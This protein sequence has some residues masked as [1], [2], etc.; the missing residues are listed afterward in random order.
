MEAGA[1]A[2]FVGCLLGTA[3]SALLLSPPTRGKAGECVT[4]GHSM[5]AVERGSS[6]KAEGLLVFFQCTSTCFCRQRAGSE[7]CIVW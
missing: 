2:P 6:V 4:A 3:A 1:S 5:S 7:P